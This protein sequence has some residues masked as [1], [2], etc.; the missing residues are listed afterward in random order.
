MTIKVLAI[1]DVGN[2]IRTI[3]KYTKKSKI[4]L[5]NYPRD[6]AARAWLYKNS[7]VKSSQF[8]D[9]GHEHILVSIDPADCARFCSRWP[10]M[11]L[12]TLK[13]D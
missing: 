13:R 10:N 11:M 2:I 5:I 6:G 12:K 1:G 7:M 8:D 4:H 9:V 3:Q